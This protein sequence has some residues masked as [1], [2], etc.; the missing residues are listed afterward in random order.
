[1]DRIKNSRIVQFF[2]NIPGVSRTYHFV[3]AW[4]AAKI[5]RHPSRNIFVIGVTGTKGKTTTLE[6]INAILE[7]AGKRTAL[8]SSLRVK[9]GDEGRKNQTGN[10]MPGRGFIQKFLREAREEHCAYALVEVTSQGVALHRHRFI[11]WNMG[12][13]TNLAPEHIDWHGSYEKYRQAKLDFLENV[14]KCGG[15]VFLNRDDK[16]Y[17]FLE[18]AL[19]GRSESDRAGETIPYSR[20]DRWFKDSIA[21]ARLAQSLRD[22]GAPKFLLSKFNEENI[23]VAVAIAK[24]LGISDRIIEDAITNFEG[25][26]GRMEFVRKGDYTAIVDY[27]HTPESL[28]AAY[29]AARP[30]PTPYFPVPRLICVLSAAGGGRDRWKRPAMGAIADQYCDEI[31]LTNEDPYDEDPEK[32]MAEIEGGIRRADPERPPVLKTLDR[33]EAIRRAV[34]MM[35]EGDVVIGTG[36]GSEESIHVARGRTVPWNEREMFEEALKQ[37]FE[38][39]QA[40]L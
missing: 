5:N 13:I 28:E 14:L 40:P 31:I 27:A 22:E 29:A 19:A 8:L 24:D 4:A 32:I 15:K 26:P 21:K 35:R 2:Y 25:V 16:E 1:M 36:K 38:K 23:A 11:E 37:R 30:E 6:L 10:S 34:D 12:V 18:E 3:W 7:A 20:D 9:I 33:G 39:E 17:G